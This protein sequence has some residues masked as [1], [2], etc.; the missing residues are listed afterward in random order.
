[1]RRFKIFAADVTRVIKH[2]KIHKK[3][4]PDDVVTRPGPKNTAQ[5]IPWVHALPLRASWHADLGHGPK[6]K[7]R[8][9]A[10]EH[11]KWKQ[12]VPREEISDF[13]R[14]EI[15]NPKSEMPLSRD[16]AHAWLQEH[17][18]GIS[19]REA[20]RFL[21]KQ[22]QIQMTSNIPNERQKGS[23]VLERKGE[24]VEADLIEGVGTDLFKYLG[25]TGD[26]YWLSMIDCLSGFALVRLLVK[27]GTKG[28]KRKA[29][30]IV[31]AAALSIIDEMESTFA[32]GSKVEKIFT[33]HGTEFS[34]VFQQAM[35]KRGTKHRFVARASRVEKYNSDFQR[36]FYR[37][38]RLGRGSFSQLQNQAQT[39][40]NN[41]KS[42]IS[43]LTPLQAAKSPNSALVEKY[44]RTREQAKPYRAREAKIGDSVRVLVKMRKNIRSAT[45]SKGGK[46]RI[47]KAYHGRHFS[48][49]IHKI[50]RI[51][52]PD[53]KPARY[54]IHGQ[55]RDR[56]QFLLISGTDAETER[57]IE[58][59]RK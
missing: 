30:D 36:T 23:Q 3:I 57:R 8:L 14:N 22:A 11:A 29:P 32:D 5:P 31:A 42:R 18:I 34:K 6:G 35:R 25:A 53:G 39:I 50:E 1:M 55:W 54:F 21:A 58:N 7:I 51:H 12:I 17:T 20:Q 4:D 9:Y 15:L 13:L 38:A 26:W 10:K 43:K 2:L 40:T 47:Y 44:K 28:V 52:K 33:D 48:K 27:P 37:L 46:A 41:L 24:R 56:D 49:L 59:R 16:S 19:R 45:F